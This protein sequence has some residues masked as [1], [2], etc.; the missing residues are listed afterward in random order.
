MNSVKSV[1]INSERAIYDFAQEM[2]THT[3]LPEGKFHRAS[4]VSFFLI[5]TGDCTGAGYRLH[6]MPRPVTDRK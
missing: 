5:C 2:S 4:Q 6:V 1:K 3:A